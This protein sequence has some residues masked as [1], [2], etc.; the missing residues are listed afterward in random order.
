M[1]RNN[2]TINEF[3]D[4][5]KDHLFD[6]R[7]DLAETHMV[8]VKEVTKNNGMILHGLSIREENENISPTIYL[9]QF[10]N[11]FKEGDPL[12]EIAERII[13]VY[14]EHRAPS[15][16]SVDFITDFDQAKERLAMKIVNADKNAVM[17]EGTPHFKFGDLAA[18]FQV[19]VDSSE[20]GNAVVTVKDEQMK[21]WGVDTQTLMDHAKANMEYKQP[22]RIQSM[23]EVLTE[24]MGFTPDGMDDA[25][26][27]QMYVMTN[28]TKIN[29]AASMIFTEKLDEFANDH[30]ANIFILP[31]SIHEIL[32]IPDNG[33]MKISELEN[34]VR[35]VNETQVAPDEVL[36]DNVYFYDKDAK[37]LYIAAT[38]EPCV[39]E[40]DGKDFSKADKEMKAEKADKVKPADKDKAPKEAKSIKDRLAEGKE[41]ASNTPS[42]PK[43][44]APKDK[45]RSIEK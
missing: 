1:D 25:G 32:L 12:S 14:E 36:S 45:G 44:I 37:S 2:M 19:Q 6:D 39:L 4:L 28:E 5:V 27:P 8:D 30:N 21:M 33:S 42:I 23:I 41:K 24:M 11:E 3:A 13:N 29:G 31:S 35:E 18:I 7:P 43:E 9:E 22:V 26:V 15:S 40:S 20:F 17:L 16:I 34:M 10:L 38:N